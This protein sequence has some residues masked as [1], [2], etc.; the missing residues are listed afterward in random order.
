MA[1]RTEDRH[2]LEVAHLDRVD[3]IALGS[4]SGQTREALAIES[5]CYR[6][7]LP[8]AQRFTVD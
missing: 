2:P 4:A 6:Y 7:E 5:S 3:S 1:R 8:L